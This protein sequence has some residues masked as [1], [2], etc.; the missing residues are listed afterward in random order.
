[1]AL[2][3]ATLA[4]IKRVLS[5]PVA[6]GQCRDLARG[7]P[8]RGR[9]GERLGHG[10]KRRDRGAGEEPGVGRDRRATRPPTP[11]ASA[12]LAERIEDDPT[13]QTRFL[14]FTRSDVAELPPATPGATR[15]KT[16]LI[17]L[18]DHKPGM[19]AL[20]L[21]AF[22][23]RGV[24]LMAL[25]SR[26]ERSAPWTYR[27]YVDVDGSAHDPRVAEA[28]EEVEALA[29]RVVVLGSYEAWIEG[30]RLS[31]P[32]PP[33]TP[34]HHTRKPD[35]PLVD[36]RR[37][38]GRD[39]GAGSAP[40]ASA[41]EEPV[42]IAGTL[43]GRERGDDPGDGGGGRPGWAPTCCGVARTSPAPRRTTSRGSA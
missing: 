2:P 16:S 12:A 6:L 7:A 40:R 22:G 9:A 39:A 43:L 29:A 17:V 34:A 33:P 21:Q 35:I 25:Q 19:L 5:H 4:G 26:P 24:N 1:M 41:G 37:Q 13:N 27:F 28:L 36:R 42:L 20:T 18:I 14:T 10:G 23:V 38:P 30:S 3:G 8:A 11:T 32:A 31:A 15:Y